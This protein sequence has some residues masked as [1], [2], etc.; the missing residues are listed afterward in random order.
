MLVELFILFA[1]GLLH[2]VDMETM[3]TLKRTLWYR[4]KFVYPAKIQ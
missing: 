4:S 2:C 3:P 1:I